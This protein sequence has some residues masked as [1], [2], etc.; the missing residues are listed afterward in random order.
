M[1]AGAAHVGQGDGARADWLMSCVG[2][3]PWWGTRMAPYRSLSGAGRSPSSKPRHTAR[4][5]S[6]PLHLPGTALCPLVSISP[7]PR[8]LAWEPLPSPDKGA[9]LPPT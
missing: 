7:P 9:V 3:C 2:T 8:G 4:A 5:P 6:P 1:G